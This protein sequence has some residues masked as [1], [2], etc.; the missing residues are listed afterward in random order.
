MSLLLRSARKGLIG[1]V[2][3]LLALGGV[4]VIGATSAGAVAA[5]GANTFGVASPATTIFLSTNGQLGSNV[6]FT[7]VNDFAAAT[8]TV[9]ITVLPNSQLSNN[10]TSGNDVYFAGTPTATASTGSGGETA[11]TITSSM[12]VAVGDTGCTGDNDVLTLTLPTTTAGVATDTYTVTITGMSYDVGS[13]ASLG[14]VGLTYTS[15]VPVANTGPAVSNAT[16]A[17]KSPAGATGNNPQVNVTDNATTQ[18]VS[19]I[20]VTEA[21]KDQ[22]SGSLCIAPITGETSF[23]FVGSPSV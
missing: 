7:L 23:T 6:T 11:P 3:G 8:N 5:N 20:V 18:S 22:V 2:A 13:A 1:V 9:A 4:A 15:T 12:S 21:A 16:V 14:P 19:N 17:V 10:C